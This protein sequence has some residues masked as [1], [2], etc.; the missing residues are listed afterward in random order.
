ARATDN[1]GA[2]TISAASVIILGTTPA[3]FGDDFANRGVLTGF[4]N[5]LVGSSSNF[6]REAG[7]PKHDGR[8]GAHSGWLTWTAP[9]SGLCV[10]DTFGSSFD[11]VL[12]VYT[13]SALTNLARVVSNDDANLD[14][15]DSQIKFNVLAGTAYQ[16]ALDGFST[17][18]AGPYVF[19]CSLPNPYPVILTQPQ[20]LV[21]TQGMTVTF[22]VTAAGPPAGGPLSYQWRLNNSAISNAT[23]S[24]LTRT[25]VGAPDQGTYVAVVS[26]SAG[27][28]TS[29]P[30][31]L[32]VRTAPII[33]TQPA[34]ATILPGADVTFFVRANGQQPFTYQ[35]R[36][37]DSPIPD[38]TASNLVLRAVYG[39]NEGN[40][41]VAIS[42]P[43]GS[44]TSREAR[45]TVNDGLFTVRLDPVLSITNEW[46][47]HA[48]GVDLGTAWRQPGYDDSGWSN[49]IGLFGL[50]EPGIYP[51][52]IRTPLSL[53]GTNGAIL[54]Y[55][56]RTVLP[57]SDPQAFGGLLVTAYI[58]D[59]AVWYI[60]GREGGRVRMSANYPVDGVYYTNF[61]TGVT[62][63]G[64]AALLVLPLTNAVAG[65]N[66]LAVEVHQ[67]TATSS[68]IVFG[69]GVESITPITNGPVLLPPEMLQA[70]VV[71]VTLIGI[72][73]RNYSIDT[74]SNLFNWSSV[75][76]FTDFTNSV[77]SVEVPRQHV[78]SRFYRG[79]V[80]PW[81]P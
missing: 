40:Y 41:S 39:R 5:T 6:T 15:S 27:S 68:D 4:T 56:F 74:S 32:T 26:N 77:D 21:V 69:I 80:V 70:D 53:A 34:D 76:T 43:L 33:T 51:D 71:R 12:A 81:V 11:T 3:R 50:E 60:N 63:E 30:A 28:V 9:A 54:T 8:N 59:G 35:W 2:V 19:H 29:A 25:N 52:P 64:A 18:A 14:T 42:N 1:R 49:G 37:N 22:S 73:G 47:Y 78:G 10:M 57:L 45:L 67:N 16:I 20:G 7:E 31:V 48:F 61:A 23:S 55:Y 58:D 17:N 24:T 36:F 44:T 75:V 62:T 79:R 72:P 65:S 46:R 66:T 38:A 13:N